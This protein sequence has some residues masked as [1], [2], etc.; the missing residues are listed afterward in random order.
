VRAT[1]AFQQEEEE[2]VMRIRSHRRNLVVWNAS[3]K[4]ADRYGVRAFTERARPRRI[5]W[6]L[7]TGALLTIM[8]IVRLARVMHARWRSVLLI[9]GTPLV[10]I[11]IMLPS[12]GALVLGMLVLLLALQGGAGRSHCRAADQMTAAHW[13]A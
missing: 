1:L 7:R 13:H 8:G 6:W 12:G 9:T 2:A 3:G 10:V 4:S 5:R 11:G